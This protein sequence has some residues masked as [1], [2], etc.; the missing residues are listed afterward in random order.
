VHFPLKIGWGRGT[1]LDNET[2]KPVDWKKIEAFLESTHTP[3][4]NLHFAPFY[5]GEYALPT[6]LSEAEQVELAVERALR[7]VRAVV[8]R[9]GPERVILENESPVLEDHPFR[10][11]YQ[12][13]AIRGV[14]EAAPCGF[15][16]DLSH[17]RLAAQMLGVDAREYITRLPVDRIREIH[18]TG[19][20]HFGEVWVERMRQAGVEAQE[21]ERFAGRNM[22]HLP[23]TEP[24]WQFTT[25]ALDQVRLGKW[26]EPW[27][28]T[29]EYGGV[30]SFWGA[31]TLPE[32][33]IEQ[34]PRL[35][36]LIRL[37]L[38]A[39]TATTGR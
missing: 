30:G 12:P 17:A 15:L 24:D 38:P 14:V 9:F 1:A 4:I 21:I 20:Q 16:F 27:V 28:A 5:E 36:D 31:V 26:R 37:T 10:A 3:L 34:V 35:Y 33:L 29:L 2:G 23:L 11:V 8:Q 25:W 13:E 19:I 7:D 18:L 6:G 22:D 39:S 32:V